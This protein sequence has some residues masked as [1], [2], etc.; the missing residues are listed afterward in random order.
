M[1]DRNGGV[2]KLRIAFWNKADKV[3]AMGG[4]YHW[5]IGNDSFIA[6]WQTAG[7]NHFHMTVRGK[8]KPA[9]K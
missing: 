6:D 5:R 4:N 8:A 9:V 2:D 3:N 1:I 7:K